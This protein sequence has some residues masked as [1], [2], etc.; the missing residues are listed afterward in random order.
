M[1][2]ALSRAA[3]RA[4]RLMTSQSFGL[5]PWNP[6]MLAV[7]ALLLGLAATVASAVPAWRASCVEPMTALRTD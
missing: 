5:A 7:A 4:G 1:G 2:L 6:V 3:I